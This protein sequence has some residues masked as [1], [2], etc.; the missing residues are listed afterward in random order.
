MRSLILALALT[1]PAVSQNLIVEHAPGY[2]QGSTLHQIHYHSDGPFGLA[3]RVTVSQKGNPPI[4]YTIGPNAGLLTHRSTGRVRIT[5]YA[6]QNTGPK[7]LLYD[8]SDRLYGL[9][10][11]SM[12]NKT[13]TEDLARMRSLVILKPSTAIWGAL[14]APQEASVQWKVR[15]GVR[16]AKRILFKFSKRQTRH[17]APLWWI[18]ADPSYTPMLPYAPG[19]EVL[20]V[21]YFEPL[22][23]VHER[24]VVLPPDLHMNLPFVAQGFLVKPDGIE[25]RSTQG[26]RFTP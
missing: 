25:V 9:N 18:G 6:L 26:Y 24:R 23:V 3:A 8:G 13:V 1:A 19:F 12:R 7:T 5:V 2:E 21:L 15:C 17:D 20:P 22:A 14:E 4:L 11:A 16:T 10:S